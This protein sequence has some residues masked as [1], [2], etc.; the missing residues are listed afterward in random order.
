M[1]LIADDREDF[2]RVTSAQAVVG[3]VTAGGTLA[4]FG[5][6]SRSA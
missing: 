4:V 5:S 3:D 6:A 2:G 1:R